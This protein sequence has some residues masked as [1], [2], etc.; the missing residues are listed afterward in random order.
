MS[1]AAV[2]RIIMRVAV[3]GWLVTGS[4]IKEDKIGTL[5]FMIIMIRTDPLRRT[6]HCDVFN[7]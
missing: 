5:I 1:V 2:H 6:K 3:I 7:S 4:G